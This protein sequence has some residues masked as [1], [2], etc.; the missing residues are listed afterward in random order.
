[1]GDEGAIGTRGT[2]RSTA[3]TTRPGPDSTTEH[4]EHTE[5]RCSPGLPR[6]PCASV[7]T[8]RKDR[9][10][11][12][13]RGWARMKNRAS[14][15]RPAPISAD[16]ETRQEWYAFCHV[17]LRPLRP[18]R[19]NLFLVRPRGTSLNVAEAGDSR[20]RASSVKSCRHVDTPR[21]FFS[22]RHCSDEPGQCC[23]RQRRQQAMDHYGRY[24][25]NG[26]RTFFPRCFRFCIL[27]CPGG[28]DS[29][30]PGAAPC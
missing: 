11:R 14:V 9:S 19:F 5:S 7:V 22:F 29:A 17:S 1:M 8:F 3:A 21:S 18:L 23:E 12:G 30:V 16:F 20:P 24:G 27:G 13:L 28:L 15:H 25:L 26:R 2:W 4:A 10:Y 6:A